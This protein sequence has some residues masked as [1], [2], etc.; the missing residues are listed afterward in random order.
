MVHTL[1]G[2]G[3]DVH[4]K[5]SIGVTAF[6]LVVQHHSHA[7]MLALSLL[8]GEKLL[9]DKSMNGCTAGHWTAFKG[10]LQTMKLLDRFGIDF[11]LDNSNM[12]PRRSAVRAQ[13]HEMAQLFV[14]RH[15]TPLWVPTAM[16][17]RHSCEIRRCRSSWPRY[18]ET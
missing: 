16:T 10:D 18:Q 13:K 11:P 12:N 5:D 4:A 9:A 3:A 1:P 14:A 7:C 2:A 15:N 8:G 6:I 17:S